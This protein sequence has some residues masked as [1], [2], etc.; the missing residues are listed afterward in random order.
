[1]AVRGIAREQRAAP[2]VAVD[3]H[4]LDRPVADADD[5]RMQVG[6]LEQLAHARQQRRKNT[7]VIQRLTHVRRTRTAGILQ[8][9]RV[10]RDAG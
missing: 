9:K 6:D 10:K 3:Q 8:N 4:A 5:V 1:M 7:S 2:T